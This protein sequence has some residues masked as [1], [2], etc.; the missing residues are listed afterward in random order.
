VISSKSCCSAVMDESLRD[1][2]FGAA[3][4]RPQELEALCA[5]HAQDVLGQFRTWQAVPEEIRD[6]AT[7]L[8]AWGECLVAIATCMG[9]LGYPEP[10]HSLAGGMD[11]VLSVWTNTFDRA[12]RLS[13]NGTH[14]AARDALTGLLA[15]LARAQGPAAEDLRPK[16]AGLLGANAL[17]AGDVAEAQRWNSQALAECEALDDRDGM[18]AYRENGELLDVLALSRAHPQ[19]GARV[20]AC[21]R[22]IAQA[23][24]FS[25]DGECER[26]TAILT[27]VLA[28]LDRGLMQRYRAKVL[29]QLGWNAVRTGDLGTA[30]RYTETAL[31]ECRTSGDEDGVRIYSAN[32]AEIESLERGAQP[33]KAWRRVLGRRQSG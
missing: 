5:R 32:L 17:A 18:R 31:S 15:D 19:E 3:L 11:D 10:W 7:S 2:L 13:E 21:R 33:A 4:H 24:D 14:D 28:G 25:D 16:V 30:R 8:H 12:R 27:A 9:R 23:Q 26:S 22:A 6:D 20:I 29:G 1:R